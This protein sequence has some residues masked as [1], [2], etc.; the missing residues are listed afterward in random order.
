MSSPAAGGRPRPSLTWQEAQD[1]ELKTGPSP[2]RAEV[3]AGA[4]TQG[5]RKNEFPM[6]NVFRRVSDRFGAGW[7]KASPRCDSGL[8]KSS[9]VVSPPE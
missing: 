5:F 3:E 1:C 7:E 8:P 2:S 9:M 4:V 6:K